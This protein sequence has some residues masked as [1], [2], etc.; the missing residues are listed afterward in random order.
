VQSAGRI[1][2]ALFEVV[3]KRN[4]V[5][6]AHRLLTFCKVVD[7]KIWDFSHPLRQFETILK[8]DILVKLEEKKLSMSRLED[9]SANEIGAMLRYPAIGQT[10]KNCCLQFP[11]M[12]VSAE[13]QP[14]TRTILRV[15][16]TLVADFTWHDRAH[17]NV[18]PWW[19]WMED[20]ANET[21]YHTEYFLL[22]KKQRF[23]E[24][25]LAFTIP[26]FEPLPHQ[27]F[28]RVISDRWLGAETLIEVPFHHLILPERHAKHTELLDLQPLPTSAL[29]HAPFEKMCA[30]SHFN[31]IQTQCFHVL[32]HTDHN[33]L[34]GAPTGSGKTNCAEIA[35][36]RVFRFYPG[37]KVVYI[38][39]LKALVRERVLDWNKRMVPILGIKMTELTGDFSPDIQALQHADLLITTPEKWDSI[40]RNWQHRTYVK[41]VGLVV[42]DE[43]HLLGNDRGPVLEAIV[44]RMRYISSQQDELIRIVGLSTALANARDVADW[45][46]IE[47]I[48]L[49]NFHP[50][51]RPVPMEVHIQGFA[52]K[53]Y[54]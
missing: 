3:L 5:T 35:I 25:K 31:P 53:H 24:H 38:A 20:D 1:F 27:Y 19:I 21:I 17:G 32:Y 39:P 14:I 16:L 47:D 49:Y 46:G 8:P 34:I 10:I 26:I 28:V 15:Q 30:H 44:S 23:E 33:A 7:R 43:I 22:H 45:L 50:S 42:I 6:L 52:G 2:R 41:K 13:I 40:S 18:E 37:K 36:F 4:W 48:G 11:R 12:R 29:Q 9:M 54:W 51:V